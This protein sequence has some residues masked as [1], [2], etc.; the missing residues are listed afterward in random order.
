MT[1][2]VLA[3]NPH[4][5]QFGYNAAYRAYESASMRGDILKAGI[6]LAACDRL[7]RLR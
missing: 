4:Y 2:T 1:L 5:L 7:A 3:I 6:W